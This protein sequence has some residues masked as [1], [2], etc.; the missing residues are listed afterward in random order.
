MDELAEDNDTWDD[1]LLVK[2]YEQACKKV[3]AALEKQNHPE[4]SAKKEPK[5]KK[6]TTS[7]KAQDM[8]EEIAST[9]QE[10]VPSEG[11]KQCHST[12]SSSIPPPPPS[13]FF[14]DTGNDSLAS[15]EE[16]ALASMLMS[17]YMSG[18][19]TGYYQATKKFLQKKS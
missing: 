1:T 12:S 5:I 2:A 6:K 8:D 7:S 14:M 4:P 13:P 11:T 9:S 19:H 17:W 3:K 10:N 18:Y 16:D 15:S